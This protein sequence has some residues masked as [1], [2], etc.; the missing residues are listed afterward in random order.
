MFRPLFG[1]LVLA[2]SIVLALPAIAAEVSPTAGD[3]LPT[4]TTSP[5]PSAPPLRTI[6]EVSVASKTRRALSTLPIQ[7]DLIG[8]AELRSIAGRTL[9]TAL[10][11]IPGYA[12]AGTSSWFLGPHS[13]YA[14]LRGLGPGSVLVTFDGVPLND[15]LGSWVTWGRVPKLVVESIEAAHGGASALYGSQALGG[16]IAVEA[17]RPRR[18]G[19]AYDVFTGNPGVSGTALDIAHVFP[20]GWAINAYEDR[21]DSKGYVRGAGAATSSPVDPY[22]RY[23]GQRY[24]VQLTRGQNA[25]LLEFGTSGTTEHRSGDFSGP[26]WYDGRTGFARYKRDGRRSSFETVAY[27]S[28]DAY[29][30]NRFAGSATSYAQT[31]SAFTS[32]DSAGAIVSASRTAGNVTLT[33][34]ADGRNVAG[35]RNE[36]RFAS[37]NSLVTGLQQFAGTYV[38]IDAGFARAELIAGARYDIYSQRSASKTIFGVRA[39]PPTRRRRSHPRSLITS[40]RASRTGTTWLLTGACARRSVTHSRRRTGAHSTRRIRSA[41]ARWSTEI[42]CCKLCRPISSKAALNGFPTARRVST[43]ACIPRRNTVALCSA[44]F[45]RM[46]FPTRTSVRPMPAGMRSRS[47]VL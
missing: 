14:E 35:S 10:A 40:A 5:T 30:F 24:N 7:A 45:L 19:F 20:G 37:P 41:A 18:D 6:G 44:K 32:L 12:Q 3:V 47:N 21:T 33:I 16:A 22:A 28:N 42:R 38:Q 31:G 43:Q 2:T 15:P 9:E 1:G 34:G 8:T 4:A 25:S 17:V 23:T 26:T 11:A 13:N 27:L 39:T 29:T 46:F 36:P